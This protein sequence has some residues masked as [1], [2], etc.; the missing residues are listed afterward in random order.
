MS[1]H[2]K[3]AVI[4]GR[5]SSIKQA[6]RGDGLKS[7]E[8]RCREFAKYQNYEVVQFF[9]DDMTGRSADRPGMKAML[10]FLNKQRSNDFAVIIDDISR[11]ARGLQVHIELREA[12]RGTG[13][14]LLSPSMD[15]KD[16][17]DSMLVEHLLASVAEHHS[18]KNRGQTIDRMRGRLLNGYWP[19][20]PPA[21]YK[22]VAVTGQGKVLER[23]EPAASIMAE[24]LEGFATGRFQTQVEVKRFLESQPVFLNQLRSKTLT[25]QRIKD[26]LTCSL[27]AGHYAYDKWDVSFRKGHHEPLISLETFEKIQDRL[28]GRAK[29]PA[30]KD[31][32]ADFPLRGF[33]LCGDCDESLTAC[34]SK[35]NGGR[36]AYYYC[37]TKGC[38]SRSKMIRKDKIEGEFESI[39]TNTAPNRDFIKIA[40][41]MLRDIWNL[42]IEKAAEISAE[43]KRQIVSFDQ[44]IEKLVERVVGTDTQP[45]IDRYEREIEKLEIKKAKLAEKIAENGRH[46]GR[47][48][49]VYRTALRFLSKPQKLWA[50]GR[51]EHQKLLLRM[52]FEDHLRYTR[53]KGFRTINMALPFRV[54]GEISGSKREMARSE[55]FEPPTPRFVVWCSIQLSYERTRPRGRTEVARTLIA[56]F[57]LGKSL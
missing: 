47:F 11:L 42:R 43:M 9:G 37:T 26:F 56:C 15:F 36:Y 19:F 2:T 55:G 53:D 5:V 51:I 45:V 49:D 34:W 54:L 38:E 57:G 46:P 52:S 23:I 44:Q 30:R 21:T 6:K 35:G 18:G 14:M 24:A 3:K 48:S 29:A 39:L 17:P 22:H 41:S 33:V 12:I 28:N 40:F 25:N 4:Y 16:D 20:Q 32:N 10:Q 27:Y 13:A 1:G 31:I 8:V 7:Q 50:S